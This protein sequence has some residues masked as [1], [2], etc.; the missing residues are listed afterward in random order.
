[1]YNYT[2]QSEKDFFSNAN[3]ITQYNDIDDNKFYD[4]YHNIALLLAV[5]ID[6]NNITDFESYVIKYP[7]ITN[8]EAIKYIHNKIKGK[9][10]WRK[11]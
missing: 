3:V 5:E 6:Q 4:Y 8:E 10:Q 9:Q 1:M 7:I 11:N 2:P